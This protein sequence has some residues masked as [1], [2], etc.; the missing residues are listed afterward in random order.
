M[1]SILNKLLMAKLPSAFSD[2][3]TPLAGAHSVALPG[4]MVS[5]NCMLQMSFRQS[6]AG[7]GP[8]K[9]EVERLL[10][11]QTVLLSPQSPGGNASS[12]FQFQ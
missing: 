12:G 6:S 11:K 3:N 5:E 8:C 9:S 4:D 10:P 7:S 1:S 2:Q